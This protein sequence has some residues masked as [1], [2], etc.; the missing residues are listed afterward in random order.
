[1]IDYVLLER[2][3]NGLSFIQFWNTE[4]VFQREAKREAIRLQCQEYIGL[5]SKELQK[6]LKIKQEGE[7]EG[8]Q[9]NNLQTTTAKSR[10]YSRLFFFSLA[11]SISRSLEVTQRRASFDPQRR[12]AIEALLVLSRLASFS[13]GD[14]A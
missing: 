5:L 6:I 4:E 10:D 12:Q 1:M 11:R 14:S 2:S 9:E 7:Q 13:P 3:K 8:K